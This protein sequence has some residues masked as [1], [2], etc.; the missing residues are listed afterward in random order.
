MNLVVAL[1]IHRDFSRALAVNKELEVLSDDRISHDT[2]DHLNQ[3]FLRFGR[4]T[5][6]VMEATFNWPWIADLAAARGLTPHLADSMAA[7]RKR[8]GGGKND[9]ADALHLACLS[10]SKGYFPEAYLSRPDERCR[11]DLF[12]HRRLM[13]AMRTQLKN[14]IHGFLF[15][16]GYRL[17][18]QVSDLFGRAGRAVVARIALADADRAEQEGKI[19]GISCGQAPQESL[20][21]ESGSPICLSP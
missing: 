5:D 3:Y 6:V 7:R 8:T 15:R 17:S 18:A 11:R 14:T 16:H 19:Q 4:G 9:R 10:F 21:G 1:D 20:S 2:R 13:V 12:R